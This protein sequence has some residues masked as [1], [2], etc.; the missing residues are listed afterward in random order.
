MGP[1]P[2][3]RFHESARSRRSSASAVTGG[4]GGLERLQGRPV[5]RGE[6]LDERLRRGEAERERSLTVRP[7][8]VLDRR[9]RVR[10]SS[11]P[12]S[13]GEASPAGGG[14]CAAT[15]R[16]SA[17][18]KPSGVQLASAI[19]PP[20]RRRAAAPRP[21]WRGRARTSTRR[22]RRR[23]RRS[24]RRTAAPRRRPRGGRGRAPRRPPARG[25]RSRQ[26]GDVV[27]ADH[28]AA[29][30]G[31]R[32]RGVAAPAR[33]RRA[34]ASRRAGRPRRRG[35]RRRGRS[36]WRPRRSRRSPRSPAGAP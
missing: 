30:A 35:A 32:D 15:V 19:V 23:R 17:P 2:S 21:P 33:R 29:E 4:T 1:V 10:C 11:V 13:I 26:G 18:M 22:P 27:D 9:V 14:T 20:G 34:R 7:R 36:G 12:H 8:H 31:G 5:V 3:R 25:P 28:V 24:R 6:G 16:K